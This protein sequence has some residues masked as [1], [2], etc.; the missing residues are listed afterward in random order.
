MLGR[1]AGGAGAGGVSPAE[2]GAPHL[3]SVAAAALGT[4]AV[5]LVAAVALAAVVAIVATVGANRALVRAAE[6][7]AAAGRPRG[8]RGG[9]FRQWSGRGGRFRVSAAPGGGYEATCELPR[10]ARRRGVELWA[11]LGVLRLHVS[12]RRASAASQL[13][14]SCFSWGSEDAYRRGPP[15]A[16]PR[17]R[18]ATGTTGQVQGRAEAEAWAVLKLPADCDPGGRATARLEARG[19]IIRVSLPAAPAAP[20]VLVPIQ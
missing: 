20:P 13:L 3:T 8:G 15:K 4:Q 18:A 7:L 17:E 6:A 5:A 16:R 11:H 2:W 12:P 1:R 19:R 14:E 9:D 10:A